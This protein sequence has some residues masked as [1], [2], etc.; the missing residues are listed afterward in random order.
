MLRRM[1]IYSDDVNHPTRH[2]RIDA[3][4]WKLCI[5]KERLTNDM[6]IFQEIDN[7]IC[8]VNIPECAF[9]YDTRHL[10]IFMDVQ[11]ARWVHLIETGIAGLEQ[12]AS[13]AHI[14]NER[15][16]QL[17]LSAFVLGQR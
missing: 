17:K 13:L 15:T 2:E 16:R 8:I 12:I 10:A 4:F 7:N 1:Q 6:E 11:E 3:A 5:V 14:N 9:D